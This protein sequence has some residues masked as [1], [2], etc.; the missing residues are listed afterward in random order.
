MSDP[1]ETQPPDDADLHSL[2]LVAWKE[3][4]GEGPSGISAVMHVIRNRVGRRGFGRTLHDCIYGKD[5]F[6]SM[7]V[8]SDHEF[9][10][11]PRSNDTL[12]AACLVGAESILAGEGDDITKGAVFYANLANIDKGGWFARVILGHP[13]NY[14]VTAT[15]GRHT[16][17]GQ[18]DLPPAAAAKEQVA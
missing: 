5:Q 18:I 6:A 15:I 12:F 10:L 17:F 14:P 2:A 7:S 13:Q 8:P 4:R 11:K 9:N 16:F 3:A 1:E